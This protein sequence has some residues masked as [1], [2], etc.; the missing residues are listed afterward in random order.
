MTSFNFSRCSV[1]FDRKYLLPDDM[2]AVPLKTSVV[3][4]H[5]ELLE[6]WDM[7]KSM[8]SYSINAGVEVFGLIGG[9]FSHE[10]RRVKSSQY[11]DSSITTRIS[12]KHMYYS[13]KQQPDSQLHPTLKARLLEIASFMNSND[14]QMANFLAELLIRDYG[15]HYL[16]SVDAGAILIQEDNIKSSFMSRYSSEAEKI[17]A[18]AGASFFKKLSISGGFSSFNAYDD[19]K[20]YQDHR[21]SSKVFSYGGPPF[22]MGMNVSEWEKDLA[23]NLIAIDRLGKP[24]YTLITYHA[25][26]PEMIESTEIHLLRKL[27]KT[28]THRYYDFNTHSGCT[29]PSK[30][31]FDY[32]ANTLEPGSCKEVSKDFNFG[33]VFQTCT[34][35]GD[36][37]CGD[38]IQKN[39]L[40]G[41]YSC[42]RGYNPIL[43]VAAKTTAPK[44]EKKCRPKK[45]CTLFVFCRTHTRCEYHETTEVATY[46]TFWCAPQ[47][48][49][50]A[51]SGGY[52]FGGLFSNDFTNPVTRSRNCPLHY[53]ALKFGIQAKVCVSEDTELGQQYSLSFGGFFSCKA[54]NIL[55]IDKPSGVLVN[56]D[57]WP[58]KCPSGF[59]QHLAMVESDC[60]VNY[61]VKAGS[62]QTPQ[63]LEIIMPPFEPKPSARENASRFLYA[64]QQ[65]PQFKLEESMTGA[66]DQSNAAGPLSLHLKLPVMM[67]TVVAFWAFFY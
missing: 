21:T 32:Q 26:Q 25:L 58:M 66:M 1:T 16:T 63:D 30:R 61:C 13:I 5:A 34:S 10:F 38:V 35:N 18:A 27:V 60:R 59:T 39:P 57:Q 42:P 24:L 12:L 23:N 11:R 7:W 22:R 50:S 33:G 51:N 41:D 2:F 14:S 44:T 37:I 62:L 28:V 36:S 6:H 8:T 31:N 53:I 4:T 29:L 67:V 17:T 45:K 47:R 55:R 52:L 40:T 9:K 49:K 65:V 54:G 46:R 56:P 48:N 20:G 64:Y 43:L 15:T 3:E 19:L